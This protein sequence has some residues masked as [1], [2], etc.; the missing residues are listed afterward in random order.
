MNKLEEKLEEIQNDAMGDD[1]I[2]TYYP[3]AKII[4]YSD[5]KKYDTI[6]KLLPNNKDYCFLLYLQSKNNGHWT[7]LH[8]DDNVINFFCSYGSTPSIPLHWTDKSQR[9]LLWGDVPYLDLLLS[10]TKKNVIY[11]PID[12][13]NK[14]DN[15]IS[16]CGRHCCLRLMTY[17][18]YGFKLPDYYKMMKKAKKNSKLNYDELVSVIINRM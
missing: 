16:T 18:N 8:N 14:H 5:L 9:E 3:N 17:L 11:N 1:T 10:K 13:Q 2:R 6:E 4:T 12:Y 7:L 15:D